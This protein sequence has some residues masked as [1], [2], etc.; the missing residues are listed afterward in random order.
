MPVINE[1]G[2]SGGQHHRPA[3]QGAPGGFHP[4][5]RA[6]KGQ[7]RDLLHPG[8]NA[9]PLRAPAHL[10]PQGEAVTLTYSI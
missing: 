5:H 4:L 7:G 1:G 2:G 10:L 3:Q 8:G 6:G 9:E